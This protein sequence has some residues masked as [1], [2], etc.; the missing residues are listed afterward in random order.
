MGICHHVSLPLC[1]AA[2]CASHSTWESALNPPKHWRFDC[3]CHEKMSFSCV[4][5]VLFDMCLIVRN[6]ESA[7]RMGRP[8]IMTL[9]W[10]GNKSG[11]IGHSL[12]T[13]TLGSFVTMNDHTLIELKVVHSLFCLQRICRTDPCLWTLFKKCFLWGTTAPYW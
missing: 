3:R 12:H 10:P 7:W 5:A 1:H 2:P 8:H 4:K 9:S 11:F 13:V 6:G